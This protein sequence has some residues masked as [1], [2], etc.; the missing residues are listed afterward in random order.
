MAFTPDTPNTSASSSATADSVSSQHHSVDKTPVA[1]G[2]EMLDRVVKG[3]HETVDRL[4]EG[5]APHVQRLSQGVN[6]AGEML[7]ERAGGMR[8]LGDEWTHSLRI[9]VREHPV[10]AV[11]TALAVG[12]L[13][14]RLTA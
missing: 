11:V 6:K 13:L 7:H 8:D 14:A 2:Q 10:A 4:A 5:A 9:T 3:A 12:V 1:S